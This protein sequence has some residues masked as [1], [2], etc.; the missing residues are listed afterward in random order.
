[1]NKISRH[2]NVDVTFLSMDNSSTTE[3]TESPASLSITST[4]CNVTTRQ[5]NTNT[6]HHQNH[7][8]TIYILVQQCID[9]IKGTC[10]STAYMSQAHIQKHFT[11]SEMAADWH[12]QV[13]P[14]STMCLSTVNAF[15]QL[16][17]V[18]ACRHTTTPISH[19]QAFTTQYT[20][21]K[22]LI[23]KIINSPSV[24][25]CSWVGDR[26][27]IS[28]IKRPAFREQRCSLISNNPVKVLG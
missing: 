6:I 10:Y 28:S 1:M 17:H 9:K 26:N 15:E 8:H 24:L 22:L 7:Q 13:I 25:Q 14:Q 5:Q 4:T 19:T 12:K 20:A 2:T 27:T 11:I 3:A 18:A 16:D 23:R 21:C